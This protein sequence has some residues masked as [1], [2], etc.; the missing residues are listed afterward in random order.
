MTEEAVWGQEMHTYFIL[1]ELIK[2]GQNIHNPNTKI[3]K[4]TI[5]K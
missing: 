5:V 1:A 4:C 3:Y 2:K